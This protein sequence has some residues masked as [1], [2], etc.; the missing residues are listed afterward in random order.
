M[1][2]REKYPYTMAWHLFN[3]TFPVMVERRLLL[4]VDGLKENSFIETAFTG[5]E[6]NWYHEVIY[7]EISISKMAYIHSTGGQFI[8]LKPEKYA[9]D[10]YEIIVAHLHNWEQHSRGFLRR[11]ISNDLRDDLMA[12]D[13]LA[14]DVL[15]VAKWYGAK[16]HNFADDAFT[17]IF[18]STTDLVGRA[19]GRVLTTETAKVKEFTHEGFGQTFQMRGINN[20]N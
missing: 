18:R 3:T 15:N 10:V 19:F 8:L 20:V 4:T 12:L 14:N 7:N 9:K 16:Q 1:L 17:A 2:C 13:A 5:S 6:R 11:D